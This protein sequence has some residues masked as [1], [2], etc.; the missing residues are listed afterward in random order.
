MASTHCLK[1]ANIAITASVYIYL[2]GF[3]FSFLFEV[4][5]Y[6]T[7]GNKAGKLNKFM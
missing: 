1:G 5:I 3:L 4:F 7:F 6:T 2:C